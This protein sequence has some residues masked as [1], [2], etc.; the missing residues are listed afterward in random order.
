MGSWRGSGGRARIGSE[1]G[2]ATVIAAFGMVAIMGMLSLAFTVGQLRY[3]QRG[4]Q[5]LA[6]SAAL[7]SVLELPYC[8]GSTNCT[9]MKTAATSALAENGVTV[10]NLVTSCGTIP[11]TGLTLEINAPPCGQSSKDPQF[12][13]SGNVEVYVSQ[14]QPSV[15]AG[16]MGFGA[17]TIT[18]RAEA[19]A[20][21][22]TNCIYALDP[23]G[24]GALSVAAAASITSPCGIV[25]ESNSNSALSC[26]LLGVIG[27]SKITVVGGVSNFLCAIAPAPVTHAT[28][29]VPADPLAYLPQPAMPACGTTTASPYHGAPSVVTINS[30]ATLYADGAYC[31][32]III[33]S[34]A[35]VSFQP[36]V[37]VLTSTNGGANRSPGGLTINLGTSVTGTGVTFFNDGPSGG[38]N[39]NAPSLSLAGVN[40]VAPTT[41]TYAGILFFQPA[42]NTS[43][44]TL[45]GSSAYSTVLQ[46]AYYFPSASVSFCFNGPVAYNI[47]VAYRISFT[48]LTFGFTTVTS[49]FGNDYSSLANGSPLAGIAAVL[50]Q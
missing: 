49:G 18:A 44:A 15:F 29:P 38:I 28:M 20:S 25:V 22:G 45:Y 37:Y 3:Q 9:V 32:G 46:G 30:N 6:D 13:K 23:S 8:A 33:N 31:G 1:R 12:G 50:S 39:F 35:T 43:A 27:V 47:L 5:K 14:P 24:S 21:G 17:T 42:S 7:A 36:G 16:T 41:G 2:S 4:L 26:A 34:G 19:A 10:N 48:L 40:L 11:A